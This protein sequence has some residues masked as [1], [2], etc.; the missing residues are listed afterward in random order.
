MLFRSIVNPLNKFMLFLKQITLGNLSNLQKRIQLHGYME[1]SVMADEFNVMLDEI[2]FLT[3]RLF[4]TTTR[5]YQVELMKG[6]AELDFLRSQIKPHFLYN[7]LE[8]IIG[9][10]AEEENEKIFQMTKALSGL[11]RYS[12]KGQDMVSFKEELDILK[13]YVYIQKVRFGSRLNVTYEVSD[14]VLNC[15][16]PKLIFQPIVENAICHGIEPKVGGGFLI[17]K[18]MLVN[19]RLTVVIKDDGVGI[20]KE[21]LDE[22]NNGGNIGLPNVNKRIKLIYGEEYG[23]DIQSKKGKGTEVTITLP[24]SFYKG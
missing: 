24:F 1:I 11:F 13:G 4:E 7:T 8:S 21:K 6:R 15:M 20:E 3:R 9:I 2:N 23:M 12:V 18:G 17:F 5:L 16:V 22:I 14:Y 19:N 10:A